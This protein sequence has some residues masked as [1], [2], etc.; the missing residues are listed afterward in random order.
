MNRY[1]NAVVVFEGFISG[2]GLSSECGSLKINEIHFLPLL[3]NCFFMCSLKSKLSQTWKLFGN[4][5]PIAVLHGIYE[6]SLP[7]INYRFH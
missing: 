7:F 5:I 6:A 3:P 4:V 2:Q 1:P